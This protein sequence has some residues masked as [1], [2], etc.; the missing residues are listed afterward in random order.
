MRR[1]TITSLIAALTLGSFVVAASAQNTGRPI[2]WPGL[3]KPVA[4][5]VTKWYSDVPWHQKLVDRI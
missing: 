5:V 3:Q 4:P 2:F 1:L